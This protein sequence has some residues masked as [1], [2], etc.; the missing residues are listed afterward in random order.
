MTECS[1]GRFFSRWCQ[2]R[3]CVLAAWLLIAALPSRTRGENHV[4][5]RY[6]DYDELDDRM[7]VQTFA[8]HFGWELNSRLSLEGEFVYDALS[9]ATPY[10]AIPTPGTRNWLKEI[11]PDE[12]TAGTLAAGIRWGGIHT[13]TPQFAYSLEND[14]ESIGFSVNHA[15]DFNEK[16]TTLALGAAYTHDNIFA[17]S[18]S[19]TENKDSGDL[20]VGVTQLLGPKTVLTANL[21]LGTAGGYM[22]DPY[23]GVHI[24]Y[25]PDPINPDPTV[26]TFGEDRPSYRYKQ[27]CFLSLTHFVTPAKG[28]AEVS[29]RFYHDSYGILSH[30]VQLAWYQKIGKRV[31]VS[32]MFRFANQNE[33]DFYMTQLPGDYTLND[34]SDPYYA[35][36]PKNYSSD[37][38]LAAMNTFTYGVSITARVVNRLS[39]DLSYKRY[40]TYGTDDVTASELFPKANVISGGFRL[41]F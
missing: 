17:D 39:L 28:S 16:N 19:S 4:D 13:T 14:Y 27:I 24:P 22:N 11:K 33:A 34:P 12:R 1:P 8:T 35:P 37:Y 36:L 31:V 29:Y 5:F 30:T 26:V 15:I 25:Y 41:W 32:P 6:E 23:K 18:L 2:P 20:L 21:T 9:G 38:R 40:E 3:V 7:H 10:G